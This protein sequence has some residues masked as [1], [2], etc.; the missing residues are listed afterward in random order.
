MMGAKIYHHLPKSFMTGGFGGIQI[1]LHGDVLQRN[2][3]SSTLSGTFG[4]NHLDIGVGT[5]FYL[6][7]VPAKSSLIS[8]NGFEQE[9]S[10]NAASTGL[11]NQN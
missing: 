6:T 1:G 2:A 3:T 9:A 11:G 10:L 4:N 7:H 8:F 5:G